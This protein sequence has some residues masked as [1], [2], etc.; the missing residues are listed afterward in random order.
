VKRISQSDG[1]FIATS[2]VVIVSRDYITQNSPQERGKYFSSSAI[3]FS[4]EMKETENSTISIL[5]DSTLDKSIDFVATVTTQIVQLILCF[6]VIVVVCKVVNFLSSAQVNKEDEK[7]VEENVQGEPKAEAEANQAPVLE[8]D[9]WDSEPLQ[10]SN[11]QLCSP[12]IR[13][14]NTRFKAINKH[15]KRKCISVGPVMLSPNAQLVATLNADE[16]EERYRYDILPLE[17]STKTETECVPC[18]TFDP[19]LNLQRH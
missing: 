2:G 13:P 14:P 9:G 1:I 5:L 16:R 4:S 3:K 15:L 7:V 6:L 19:N 10:D 11:V 17:P 8:K 12:E 18:L